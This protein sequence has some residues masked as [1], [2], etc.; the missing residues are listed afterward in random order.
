MNKKR[1]VAQS[2]SSNTIKVFNLETGQLHRII[3]VTGTISQPPICT[4][5]EMYV[6]ITTS[7]GKTII[8]YYNIPSFNLS[9]TTSI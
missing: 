1:F 4:E 6:G 5:M 8:N 2:A 7:D 9:R 3:S